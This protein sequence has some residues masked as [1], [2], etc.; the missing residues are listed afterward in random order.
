MVKNKGHKD[1][2]P[3][4]DRQQDP[5]AQAHPVQPQQQAYPVQQ[6]Q[7]YMANNYYQ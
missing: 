4:L 5:H 6:Q 2:L 1:H 7:P 3:H